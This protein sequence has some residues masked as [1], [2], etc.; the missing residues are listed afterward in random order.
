MFTAAVTGFFSSL[1]LI[2]AIGAQNAFVLR[3]GLRRE[4][5]M[6]VVLI[7]A[8]SDA[9]LIALGVGGFATLGPSLPTIAEIMRWAG[10]VFLFIYGGMR[11]RSAWI[12]GESLLPERTS[13]SSFA[14]VIMTCLV[15][16]WANPHVYLDT[17]LLLGS[18]SFQYHPYSFEFGVGAALGSFIFFTTLGYGARLLSP[19]LANIR[20]WII[21]EILMGLTMWAIAAG[22][23][24]QPVIS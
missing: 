20:A 16:T 5:V 2:L 15:M 14:H 21:L 19:I 8:I 9:A 17:V 3:Q 1:T 6:W 12:G 23:I 4:F 24:M 18:I 22:L 11:F 10:A 7:C 13:P